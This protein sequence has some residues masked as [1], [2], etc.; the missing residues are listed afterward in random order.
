LRLYRVLYVLF[1]GI[2]VTE[3]GLRER[4]LVSGDA[5]IS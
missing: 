2:I 3:T 1:F 4:Y 5:T